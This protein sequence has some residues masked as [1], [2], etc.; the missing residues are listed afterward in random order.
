M[1]WILFPGRESLLPHRFRRKRRLGLLLLHHRK[2]NLKPIFLAPGRRFFWLHLRFYHFFRFISSV[3]LKQLLLQFFQRLVTGLIQS[4][5]R[6]KNALSHLN[7]QA[8]P[9]KRRISKLV[10][11][12]GGCVPRLQAGSWHTGLLQEMRQHSRPGMI[13]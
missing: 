9:D 7:I 3:F 8:F 11:S 13:P 1:P 5:H 4:L 6:D 2:R 10:R 12:A